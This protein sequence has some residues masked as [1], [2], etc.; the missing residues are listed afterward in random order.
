MTNL[1]S[2]T[3][4]TRTESLN[5]VR[6]IIPEACYER[7]TARAARAL[8]LAFVLYAAPVTAL[9]LT[10]RWWAVLVLWPLAGLG[11]S[12]LFVLGHDAS[13]GARFRSPRANRVIARLC[14]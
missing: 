3:T 5:D 11:V 7:S 4:R 13:H 14:M 1:L 2:G 6:A 9:A 12:G 8:A 10:D